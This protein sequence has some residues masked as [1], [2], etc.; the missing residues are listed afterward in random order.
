MSDNRDAFRLCLV[1]ATLFALFLIVLG[2]AAWNTRIA[3]L[4]LTPKP[5]VV[6]ALP[7]R[8]VVTRGFSGVVGSSNLRAPTG[9]SARGVN[10][11]PAQPPVFQLSPFNFHPCAT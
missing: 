10:F 11:P 5:P 9:V 2:I 1:I 4:P 8:G 7:S 3:F 6:S